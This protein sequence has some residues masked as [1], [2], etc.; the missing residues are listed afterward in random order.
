MKHRNIGRRFDEP[1]EV[2]QDGI[3]V[4]E[5]SWG[6]ADGAAPDENLCDRASSGNPDGD[7]YYTEDK[8]RSPT[9]ASGNFDEHNSR[10]I[11]SEARALSD[12]DSLP[13]RAEANGI[14]TFDDALRAMGVEGR[15]V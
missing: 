2:I 8:S 4:E 5:R 12:F 13:A 6:P 11:G 3:T 14:G 10:R 1:V 15:G 9:T 7:T